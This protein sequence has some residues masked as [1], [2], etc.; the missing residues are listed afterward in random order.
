MSTNPRGGA[1]ARKQMHLA[2]VTSN[3]LGA[4]PN[5]W[6]EPQVDPG[7]HVDIQAVMRIARAAERGKLDFVF[8]GDFLAQSQRSEAQPPAQLLEP[9]VLATAIAVATER[10]G[11]VNTVSTTFTEPY[12]IAR[13]LKSLDVAS[14][15]RMGWN[16]ITTSSPAAAA[17]FGRQ[18]EDRDTR[19]ARADEVIQI[20]QALWGSWQADAWIADKD[21]RRFSDLSKI[22]PINLQG[23]YVASRGPL[24][25][26]PSEQGQP[27]MCHA[28]ASPHSLALAGRYADI[29]LAEV[30]TIDEARRQRSAVRQA[31]TDAGR[32]PDGITFFAGVIPSIAATHAEALARRGRMVEPEVHSQVAYLGQL[33]GVRLGPEDLDSPLTPQQLAAA[34]PSPGDTR[35]HR[36]LEV[37]REGWTVREVLHHGVIDYHPA[38]IGPPEVIADHMQEWFEADAA[39]GFWVMPDVYADGLDALVD[40]VVPIL[41]QRGLFRT[42]YEGRT[43]RDHLGVPPQYGPRR[44]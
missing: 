32:D 8:L 5:A 34:R 24:E 14:G 17:N 36:A 1:G 26:P 28:G 7:D 25:I 42:G 2:T 18:I 16:A 15:G 19:Y 10:I 23:S 38:P 40:Q 12:N 9:T 29:M 4:H 39:D 37:A 11:I 31:A 30:F 33:V 41:Q 20:V 44:P 13:V 43:L 21:A 6:L 35:S 3:G 27:V 22:Q